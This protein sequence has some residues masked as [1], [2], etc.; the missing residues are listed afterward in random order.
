[1]AAALPK[2]CRASSMCQLPD[3]Q[4]WDWHFGIVE[5]EVDLITLVTDV[6]DLGFALVPDPGPTRG[7]VRYA[8]AL[9]FAFPNL[10]FWNDS[11]AIG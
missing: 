11:L 4:D 9:C 7:L 3:G 8:P 6:D 1:M 2:V 10:V 5:H